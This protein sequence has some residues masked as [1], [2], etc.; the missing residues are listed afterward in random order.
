L[1]EYGGDASG[2]ESEAQAGPA[3]LHHMASSDDPLGGPR[4]RE[5]ETESD[6]EEEEEDASENQA[7][8][9]AFATGEGA[10]TPGELYLAHA[11]L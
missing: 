10:H 7:V 8:P 1:L 5:L 9:H 2:S 6:E 3:L 4:A 11:L